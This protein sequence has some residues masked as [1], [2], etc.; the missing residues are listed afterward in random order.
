VVPVFAEELPTRDEAVCRE[1]QIKNW[2]HAKKEALI[3]QDWDALVR[4][5]R[6]R[7]HRD[8]GPK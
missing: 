3:A 5:A 8:D 6:G 4:L 1:R 7:S 2:S